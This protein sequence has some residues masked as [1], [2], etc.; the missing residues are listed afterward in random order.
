MDFDTTWVKIKKTVQD[1]AILSMEKIEEYSKI[2]KLKV[3]EFTAKKKIERNYHDIGQTLYM[4]IKNDDAAN[5][6]EN[7]TI[8]KAV[9]TIRGLNED[10]QK[11]KKTIKTIVEN[12][13]NSKTCSKDSKINAPKKKTAV[14]TITKTKTAIAKKTAVTSKAKKT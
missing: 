11:I 9:A 6:L 1:G 10:L 5:V 4:L 12:S 3:E 13:K 7:P 8:K 14:E 2:G